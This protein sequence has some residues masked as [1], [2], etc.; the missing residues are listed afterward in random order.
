MIYKYLQTYSLVYYYIEFAIN[1]YY[2]E[3]FF[4]SSCDHENKADKKCKDPINALYFNSSHYWEALQV[5]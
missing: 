5:S 1:C 4:A 3:M 2:H